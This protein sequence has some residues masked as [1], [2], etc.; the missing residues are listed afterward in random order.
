[1]VIIVRG[2]ESDEGVKSMAVII[3]AATAAAATA[4]TQQKEMKGV[5]A[6]LE[7]QS[8]LRRERQRE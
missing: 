2:E 4:I 6:M 7:C 1:M 8:L 3:A 5:V